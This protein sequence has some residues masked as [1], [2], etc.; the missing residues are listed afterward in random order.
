[1]R[2]MKMDRQT[3][4]MT[5]VKIGAVLEKIN[6]GDGYADIDSYA[7]SI[8]HIV[9]DRVERKVIRDFCLTFMDELMRG[10][11]DD[12]EFW[13]VKLINRVAQV[14]GVNLEDE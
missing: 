4:T 6:L 8:Y 14:Y 7:D 13:V 5:K 11:G 10:C 12:K 3:E 1:M 2:K 9:A